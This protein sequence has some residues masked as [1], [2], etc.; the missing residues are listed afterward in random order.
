MVVV[1]KGQNLEHVTY[2]VSYID[3]PLNNLHF[4]LSRDIFF[5]Y[6]QLDAIKAEGY[7][8]EAEQ[9]QGF[10][11]G[12]KQRKSTLDLK[13]LWLLLRMIP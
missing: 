7:S 11:G 4:P 3:C 2:K 6:L 5:P 1:V 8:S 13:I 12:Y 10:L 9:D